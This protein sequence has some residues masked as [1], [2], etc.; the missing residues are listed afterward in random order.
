MVGWWV[1]WW[2]GQVG[3]SRL[4]NH[5][6]LQN[7]ELIFA[8]SRRHCCCGHL[9]QGRL[10][11]YRQP[12]LQV[13]LLDELTTF[14]DYEDQENVLRCV[15]GIVDDS[16]RQAQQQQQAQQT[17]AALG[18]GSPPQGGEAGGMP[19]SAAAAAAPASVTALWVTH[20]LEELEFA[21]SVRWVLTCWLLISRLPCCQ[22]ACCGQRQA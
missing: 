9:T 21:D 3:W 2:P 1:S 6:G 16:R 17:A 5:T 10:L 12:H 7:I 15:R 19:D 22:P 18:A 4:H 14:L 20:R 8:A 11:G 13:L